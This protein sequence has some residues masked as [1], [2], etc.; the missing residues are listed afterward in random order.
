MRAFV[1]LRGAA[2][3]R[4]FF[5]RPFLKWIHAELPDGRRCW[6][7]SQAVGLVR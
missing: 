2:T 3:V 1:T 4:L 5:P 6:L 7:P